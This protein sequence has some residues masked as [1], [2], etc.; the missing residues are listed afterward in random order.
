MTGNIL[1]IQ[2]SMQVNYKASPANYTEFIVTMS[3]TQKRSPM[4][5]VGITEDWDL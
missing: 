2:S 4:L 3:T 5:G 1:W